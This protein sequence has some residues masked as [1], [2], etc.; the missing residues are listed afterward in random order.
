MAWLADDDV[1]K[2]KAVNDGP[3]LD[4]FIMLNKKIIETE[5]QIRRQQHNSGRK[6]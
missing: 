5:K 6:H 2:L 3:M 4:F 1:V